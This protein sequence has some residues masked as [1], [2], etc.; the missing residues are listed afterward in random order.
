MS[1]L[2]LADLIERNLETQLTQKVFEGALLAVKSAVM[3]SKG[4]VWLFECTKEHLTPN[5]R[6]W[7]SD[8]ETFFYYHSGGFDASD[9]QNS[10]TNKEVKQVS[11][12]RVDCAL[13]IELKCIRF[14]HDMTLMTMSKAI[15][16]EPAKLS[17]YEHNIGALVDT[18][19][20]KAIDTYCI[21]SGYP[22]TD[23]A[24]ALSNKPVRTDLS[25]AR[26]FISELHEMVASEANK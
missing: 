8:I 21:N 15:G 10:A 24:I 14:K 26:E 3:D 16:W 22:L 11:N 7:V 6:S 25:K 19:D 13:G 1:I 20:A 4:R 23:S 5:H 9:W 17:K 2:I 18:I 12:F